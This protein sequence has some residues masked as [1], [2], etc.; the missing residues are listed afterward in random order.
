P[1][2]RMLLLPGADSLRVLFI[3][4]IILILRLGQPGPHELA[5]SG[6]AALGLEAITLALVAPVIGKRT[7]LAVQ[8]FRSGSWWRHRSQSQK[9]QYRKTLRRSGRKSTW[10]KTQRGEEGRRI[11]SESCEENPAEED[12]VSNRQFC[13][14]S[15][16]ASALGLMPGKLSG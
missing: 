4:K 3:S 10:K 11:F 7:F 8:A 12:P 15:V 16:S 6:L 2:I 14:H 9:N 1:I 5:L 13:V